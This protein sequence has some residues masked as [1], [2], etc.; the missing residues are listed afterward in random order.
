MEVVNLLQNILQKR[1]YMCKL[2]LKVAFF[3]FLS[4]KESRKY[5]WFQSE[6][7]LYEFLC[8]CFGLGPARLIFTKILRYQLQVCL[9]M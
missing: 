1:D 7:T 4:K 2:D 9:S 3:V 8:L 5:K 6:K